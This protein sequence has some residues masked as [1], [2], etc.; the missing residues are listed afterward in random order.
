MCR[1]A[2]GDMVD[3]E[4]GSGSPALVLYTSGWEYGRVGRSTMF[5]RSGIE[6]HLLHY[7]EING[8]RALASAS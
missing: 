2:D 3:R 5:S 4:E 8:G 6:H 7:E 1:G